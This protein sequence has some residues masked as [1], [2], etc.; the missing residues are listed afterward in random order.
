MHQQLHLTFGLDEAPSGGLLIPHL[1]A[2]TGEPI[3]KRDYKLGGTLLAC[4][5]LRMCTV[6]GLTPLALTLL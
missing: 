4:G 5:L 2:R 6:L 3:Q 1:V